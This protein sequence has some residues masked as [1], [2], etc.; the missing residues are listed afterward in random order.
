MYKMEEIMSSVPWSFNLHFHDFGLKDDN[1]SPSD[2]EYAAALVE[3]KKAFEI[4]RNLGA[5]MVRTDFPW[6][7]LQPDDSV[8]GKFDKPFSEKALKFCRDYVEAAE[9]AQLSVICILYQAPDWAKKAGE[10]N[11]QLFYSLFKQYCKRVALT[12]GDKVTHYQIWNEPNNVTSFFIPTKDPFSLHLDFPRLFNEAE[13]GFYEAGLTN[14]VSHINLLV[15]VLTE[16]DAIATLLDGGLAVFNTAVNTAVS[17]AVVTNKAAA[18]IG[19]PVL[20]QDQI[21][22]V[23]NTLAKINRVG[24]N[25]KNCFTW[26]RCLANYLE[27]NDRYNPSNHLNVFGLDHYPG[28]WT[29]RPYNDW[30]PLQ[31]AHDILSTHTFGKPVKGL[32]VAE[33][34]FTT[35]GKEGVIKPSFD[36]I[37]ND[38]AA[39]IIEGILSIVRAILQPLHVLPSLLWVSIDAAAKAL[40]AVIRSGTPILSGI[41]ENALKSIY[42][43]DHTWAEQTTWINQSLQGLRSH[44]LH[45]QLRYI[46]WYELRDYRTSKSFGDLKGAFDF[47][48]LCED[49]FGIQLSDWITNKPAFSALTN[50]IAL[51]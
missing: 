19:A 39:A 24:T 42:I 29:A 32:A 1:L 21:D 13:N 34:G 37:A 51:G 14:W 9:G 48:D 50:Q 47:F 6:K 22:L 41:V 45:D 12:V 44:P 7:V 16:A 35:W 25:L 23:N 8:E 10:Q 38:I 28:T 46:N 5:T 49:H 31:T 27:E 3:A 40:E 43:N 26:S 30:S 20:T 15:N 33:T 17:T 11:P 36:K 2:A 4:I 18:W